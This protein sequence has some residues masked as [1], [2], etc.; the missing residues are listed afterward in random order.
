[1]LF[2]AFGQRRPLNPAHRINLQ[3]AQ[4]ASTKQSGMRFVRKIPSKSHDETLR[5]DRRG[6]NISQHFLIALS[7]SDVVFA[8]PILFPQVHRHADDEQQSDRSQQQMLAPT[9]LLKGPIRYCQDT[10]SA[11]IIRAN[12]PAVSVVCKASELNNSNHGNAKTA[13]ILVRAEF[14]A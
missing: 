7:I 6:A 14:C 2:H 5:A 8:K 1:M 9:S 3:S 13:Q 10:L 11:W 4:I 12:F